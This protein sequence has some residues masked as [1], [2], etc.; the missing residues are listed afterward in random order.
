MTRV[1]VAQIEG[2]TVKSRY[3]GPIGMDSRADVVWMGAL[4][5]PLKSRRLP[6]YDKGPLATA[7]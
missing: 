1:T 5:N 6:P 2:W 7:P 3:S 4:R